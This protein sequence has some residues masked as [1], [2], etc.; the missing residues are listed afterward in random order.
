MNTGELKITKLDFTNNIV[1]GTFW[2]DV[3]DDKG[4]LHQIREGR[5]DMQF[6]Q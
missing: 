3:K 1:S 4:V 2:F 5:F 6:T